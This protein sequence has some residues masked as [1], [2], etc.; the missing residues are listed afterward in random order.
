MSRSVS[1]LRN[2]ELVL[3]AETPGAEDED[4]FFWD[5]TIGEFKMAMCKAFPSLEEC[6]EWSGREDHIILRNQL[7]EFAV[8]EYCGLTSISARPVESSSWYACPSEAMKSRWIAQ[9]APRVA[10][11][12]KDCFGGTLNLVGRFSNG[13]AV[14]ERNVA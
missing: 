4:S 6:D 2:A 12:V 8:S 5:D 3:Y 7:A 11:I 9:V 1:Y 14:Y 10:K 13:E